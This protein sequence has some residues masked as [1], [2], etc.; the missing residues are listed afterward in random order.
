[1]MLEKG[2]IPPNIH[3]KNPNPKI[4]F[5]EHHL[6]V[7]TEIMP[8]PTEGT[9]RISVNSFGY[10]G[11]NAHVILDD[12]CSY[13]DQNRLSGNHVTKFSQVNGASSTLDKPGSSFCRVF[14]V[15]AHDKEGLGRVK[16]ALAEYLAMK[17]DQLRGAMERSRFLDDLAFT[18]S[19][20][21]SHLQWKT[22]FIA[23]SL[24][25]LLAAL[26]ADN[27][28]LPARPSSRKPRLG[29][30][31]TG[32]GA[33]WASMGMDLMR[34][35]VF[36]ESVEAADR[37]L[38]QELGC[39]WSACKELERGKSTSKLRMPQYSQGLCTVLQVGLVELLESWNIRPVAVVGHSSGEIAAAYCQG[40]VSRED[41]WRVAYF[42]GVVSA[43]L[44]A[45]GIDGSMMAV[46]LSPEGAREII[47]KLAPN[48]VHIACVNSPGSVTLSGDT[49]AIDL[50]YDALR[51]M[52]AFVRKLHVDVAYHSPHM[53][54]VARDYWG[55]IAEVSTSLSPGKC[56]MYSS[57]T[58]ELVQPGELVPVYWVRNLISPVQFATAVQ[59]L[60][61]S[62]KALDLLVEVGPHAALQGPSTQSLQNVGITDLPYHSVLLRNQSGVETALSL[63]GSLSAQGYPV[64]FRNFN[65]TKTRTPRPLVDLPAY[66]WNH[67]Q[68][69]WAETR[70]AKEYRLRSLPYNTLLGALTPGFLTGERVWTHRIRL[71]K[72]TWLQDHKI[73]GTVFYPAAGFIA[74]AIEAAL[75]LADASRT[76][77]SFCLRN[78]HLSA[79][80]GI[81]EGEEVEYSVSLRPCLSEA[82]DAQE[83][84]SWNEFNI[85][86]C[87]GDGALVRHCSGLVMVEYDSSIAGKV[88]E[89]LTIRNG[90][91]TDANLSEISD[92]IFYK[93]LSDVGF[94]YG[95]S[96]QNATDVRA[97]GGRGYGTINI[98]DLGLDLVPRP[99]VIHPATLDAVFH[100]IFGALK[101]SPDGMTQLMVPK[102]IDEVVISADIPCEAGAQLKGFSDITSRG[103][104]EVIAEL[105]IGDGNTNTPAVKISGLCL[106]EV[107]GHAET[108]DSWTA[109]SVCSSLVWKPSVSLL[110][111]KDQEKVIKE[112]CAKANIGLREPDLAASTDGQ[113]SEQMYHA[114]SELI[115]LLHHSHPSLSISEV[116]A[117]STTRPILSHLPGL[118]DV[119]KTA[120][121]SIWCADERARQ[122]AEESHPESRDIRI[123]LR[124]LIQPIPRPEAP[125]PTTDLMIMN[126][127]A[128]SPI[129]MDRLVR[130]A[131]EILVNDGRL[132][133]I[134]PENESEIAEA[135]GRS[136]GLDNWSK[137]GD[138]EN[139]E[140]ETLTLLL[141]SKSANLANGP[142]T[143]QQDDEVVI[144]QG[145]SPSQAAKR[146]SHQLLKC[147]DNHGIA[148]FSVPWDDNTQYWEGKPCISLLEVDRAIM[149]NPTKTEFERIKK[150]ILETTKTLWVSGH[151]EPSSAIVAGLGRTVRNE[152]PGLAFHTLQFDLASSQDLGTTAELILRT[153]ID[154]SGD[155]EFKIDNGVIHVS[156]V[157]E[158]NVT[159]NELHFLDPLH[160]KTLS[161]AVLGQS[162][163]PLKLS[164]QN[165]GMLS[166]LCF[167]KDPGNTSTNLKEDEVE[168]VVK[169]SSVR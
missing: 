123:E 50:V 22:Y 108:L 126:L 72:Q 76:V 40:S 117:L 98:P 110:P 140:G 19:E 102:T 79:A 112:A 57:V 20:R 62:E 118:V 150:L 10:G 109:R 82:R 29:F 145:A 25:D 149:D 127:D 66:P 5:D 132:C 161:T 143:S 2:I 159:N 88:E 42:R 115:K 147:L 55:T 8:W 80:L 33:Q 86:S 162:T 163:Q 24:E 6:Q 31:F 74:S 21:R 23:S 131:A 104:R 39:T 144:I 77:A 54:L 116:F 134:V 70:I 169:A 4:K 106:Q 158:D 119:F 67:S 96:F 15:S 63:A 37:Y 46:G 148:A 38:Q 100:L 164:I 152:E 61:T 64:R 47:S 146:L 168:I 71:S 1:M 84:S 44:K 120:G 128:S 85:A 101:G 167:D 30:V 56:S 17:S 153:F 137:I 36:R 83:T 93:S 75:L 32:Q 130:N 142:T 68:S 45:C 151:S 139:V 141:G 111:Y 155:N 49:D 51:E 95:P 34:Y 48:K 122:V 9:R 160:S 65:H 59:Q 28:V 165:A 114:I 113:N 52:G 69:H 107:G 43:K 35:R 58:G 27:T 81:D 133:L 41:A 18:L 91:M 14:P 11:S 87:R 16:L 7:P 99:H 12:A 26:L 136:V 3:F 90:E 97:G 92:D 166:S 135:R 94:H 105:V 124:D 129:D 13:L 154:G 156:R 60:V 121:C 103:F 138:F 53:Q 89:Q 73:Q 157:L 78:I 125:L